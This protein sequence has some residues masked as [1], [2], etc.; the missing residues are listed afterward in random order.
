MVHHVPLVPNTL[1]KIAC[2]IASGAEVW[3]TN[4]SSFMKPHPKAIAQLLAHQINYVDDLRQ[5]SGKRF[6]IYFDCG[7]ELHQALGK[8]TLGAVELTA[9]GDQYYRKQHLEYPVISID[10]TL[11]KQLETIFGSAESVPLAISQL[12]KINPKQKRWVIFGFGKIGRGIAY[13]CKSNK[14]DVT[15]VDNTQTALESATALGLNNRHTSQYHELQSVICH[16][17]IIVSATGQKNT[18]AAYPRDWFNHKL[19]ANMGIY[20]E[21]GAQ[22]SKKDVLNAK[23]PVNFSL[24]DPTPMKYIDPEFYAHNIA[25]LHLI[26]ENMPHQVHDLCEAVDNHIINTWCQHHHHPITTIKKWFIPRTKNTPR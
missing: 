8:P 6:D 25:A 20:D 21:Y 24:D 16:A 10:Q 9:S 1:L 23:Q 15:I 3:V 12:A 18:L 13:Y 22:F 17:D 4:P 5:L 2:L 7:G 11:T 19:L 14:I 26:K